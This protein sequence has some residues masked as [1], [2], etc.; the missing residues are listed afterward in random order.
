M[1]KKSALMFIILV[2]TASCIYSQNSV[3]DSTFR[4]CF[5][6]SSGFILSNLF[7]QE[8]PPSYYQLNVGYWLTKKDVISI[9]AKTW[10]YRFP[11]GIPYGSSFEAPGEEYP[12]KVRSVGIGLAYQRFLWKGLYSAVHASAWSQQYFNEKNE[13]IQNGFQLFTALRLG[14]HIKL[15]KNRFFIEPSFAGTYWP[16]NTN[17]PAAFAAKERKWNNF[18]LV[19]PGLHF[20]VKF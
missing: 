6:G 19:E 20:G 9:E 18:F 17:V 10:T 3:E 16:V 15:F 13:K 7:P 11:I 8:N 4:R 2:S 14:Y 1:R 5:V 12:G